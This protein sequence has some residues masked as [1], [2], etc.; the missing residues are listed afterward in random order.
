M[1]Q[2][3]GAGR[4]GARRGAAVSGAARPHLPPALCGRGGRL[5]RG[6]GEEEHVCEDLLDSGDGLRGGGSRSRGG[7]GGGGGGGEGG[8]EER[9]NGI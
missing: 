6:K 2:R 7:G 4:G 1:S 3:R 8:V 5:A 9:E